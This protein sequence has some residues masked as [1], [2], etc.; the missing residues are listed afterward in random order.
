MAGVAKKKLNDMA[1]PNAF[2][3]GSYGRAESILKTAR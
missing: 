3:L 2:N 1:H